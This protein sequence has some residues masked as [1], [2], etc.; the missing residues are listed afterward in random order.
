MSH[1]YYKATVRKH[2]SNR[3]AFI[4]RPPFR[5]YKILCS[6]RCLNLNVDLTSSGLRHST[7]TPASTSTG[8]IIRVNVLSNNSCALIKISTQNDSYD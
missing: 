3:I 2:F 7:S 4:T 1:R 5:L 8:A 6:S